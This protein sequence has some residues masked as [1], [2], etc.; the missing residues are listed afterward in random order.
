MENEFDSEPSY[1]SEPKQALKRAADATA[2]ASE[3][4][5]RYVRENPMS[6]VFGALF[7]GLLIGI[8]VRLIEDRERP[9]PKRKLDQVADWLGSSLSSGLEHAKHGYESGAERVRDT[10]D[11]A[12]E[13]GSK[14]HWSDRADDA[15]DKLNSI[16]KS[17]MK[18]VRR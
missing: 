15:C 16:R 8:I 18:M 14:V 13:R 1:T 3:C 4:A 10:L 9:A 2:E 17:L 5:T 11:A 6:A 7:V 12:I